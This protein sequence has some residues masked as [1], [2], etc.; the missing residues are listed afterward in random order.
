[1]IKLFTSDQIKNNDRYTIKHEPIS[2]IDL[3]ERAATCFYNEFIRLYS[4]QNKIYVF[5]G[6]GNNGADALA[7]ARMLHE[8][9][10]N[11]E[12][13]LFNISGSLSNDCL[14][15]RGRLRDIS[16]AVFKEVIN[17]FAFPNIRQS[18]I[19]IDGLF[20]IGLN[21]PLEGGFATL[22]DFINNSEAD[23]VSIDIPSGLFADNNMDNNLDS[24]IKANYTLTFQT[25]KFSFMLPCNAQYVGTWKVLDIGIHPDVIEETETTFSIIE[26]NDV[27]A[28][29]IKR[30]PF[31]HKGI[32]GHAL[33]I[34]GSRGKIGAALLSAKAATKSGVGLL[35]VH[36]PKCGEF[37]L[38]TAL[39]E[40]MVE[41][42]L[43]EEYLSVAPETKDFSSVGIGPG[44]GMHR[45]TDL[46]LKR[47]LEVTDKPMVIDADALNILAGNMEMQSL[48]P[49]GSI[50]TPHPKELDRLL[51]IEEGDHE[52]LIGAMFLAHKLNV[53][54]ILKGRYS[55]ICTPEKKVFFN[56]T[57]NPG[58]AT[59]GSG[60]V[61]TGL[62][63]GL[64]SQG[65]TPE[66]AAICGTYI[67]GMAGDL[68]AKRLSQIAMSSSDIV[69]HL[70]LAFKQFEDAF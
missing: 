66:D 30:K 58:M 45:E 68:A 53:Y 46:A 10:Y 27:Q 35:T 39:P 31:D 9:N 2:S 32:Y 41:A 59:G 52:R 64:L 38:Q 28:R 70:P 60:D 7:I 5:A 8:N 34:A 54:V 49:K 24:I 47:I 13:Y 23:V 57:G 62:L 69:A 3:T 25:P 36:I 6:N 22:I 15:N 11:V 67:H 33:L 17:D 19:I 14:A 51:E 44:L 37:V 61:L 43:N 55:A 48:I 16:T 21:R 50:L 12:T 18:D 1:M 4:R 29:I 26:E 40:A 20:G 42:D 63:L 56:P 65:Y